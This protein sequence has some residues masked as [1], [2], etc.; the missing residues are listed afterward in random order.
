MEFKFNDPAAD[1]SDGIAV[2]K[3]YHADLLERGQFL[4]ALAETLERQG[5]HEDLANRCIALHC[6]YHY[7]NRLHHLDEERGLFPL[8]LDKPRIID[9]MIERLMV[10]HEEIEQA[11]DALSVMLGAPAGIGDVKAFKQ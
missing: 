9:A 6:H 10:D 1:F 7:A 4:L 5:M 11:W 8:L 2:L 3:T